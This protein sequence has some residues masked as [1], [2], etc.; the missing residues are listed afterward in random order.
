MRNI[1]TDKQ[2]AA[3]PA[4]YSTEETP[5]KDK[6]IH[7]HYFLAATDWYVAE[8]SPAE[9]LFFGFC[10]LNGDTENAEWGYI[11]LDELLDL[12]TPRGIEVERD[13]HWQPTPAGQVEKIS[14]CTQH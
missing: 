1:P 2:L 6:V 10:I 14:L 9:R 8:W 11:S 5:L 13:L 3:L 4:L 7:Q 12:K